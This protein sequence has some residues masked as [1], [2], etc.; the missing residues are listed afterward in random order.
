MVSWKKEAAKV[1]TNESATTTLSLTEGL[2]GH[3]KIFRHGG[4]SVGTS[5]SIR[6]TPSSKHQRPSCSR[7]SGH[8]SGTA[9]DDTEKEREQIATTDGESELRAMCACEHG[10]I[11]L[12]LHTYT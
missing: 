5:S 6:P 7:V 8:V 2:P 4:P 1:T 10:S 11:V 12:T 9:R 3:P